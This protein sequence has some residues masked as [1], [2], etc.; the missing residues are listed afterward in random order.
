M[1]RYHATYI[2]NYQDFVLCIFSVKPPQ[3]N[4]FIMQNALCG[5]R[6]GSRTFSQNSVKRIKRHDIFFFFNVAQ[7]FAIITVI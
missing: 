4:M 3:Y 1:L 7:R 6:G 5:D 2:I